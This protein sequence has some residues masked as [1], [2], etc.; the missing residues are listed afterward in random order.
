MIR[1]CGI[2]GYGKLGS[3]LAEMLYAQG[4]LSWIC[5]HSE[6]QY[7]EALKHNVPVHY[8]LDKLEK[9]DSIILSVQDSELKNVSNEVV[10]TGLDTTTWL[11]HCS[12]TLGQE[13]FQMAKDK[14]INT[15][16]IHPFQTIVNKQSLHDI[17]WGIE[18]EKKDEQVI[19]E[20][21]SSLNGNP[22]FLSEETKAHKAAYHATAVMASNF[23]TVLT[24][25]SS[26]AASNA[27][28]DPAIFLP[29]IQKSALQ[30]A[31]AALQNGKSAL[32]MLTGPLLR[33]DIIT[34]VS[35]IESL[36]KN[37]VLVRVY[38][39]LSIATLELLHQSKRI[40]SKQYE[41]MIQQISAHST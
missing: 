29:M 19:G 11:M 10:T 13:V 20:F 36:T 33:G 15:A 21:V 38:I 3:A 18:C 16:C 12:G 9:T 39:E 22:V 25:L 32:D 2:I 4:R 17:P 5:V 7:S 31:H 30:N 28:I 6:S 26:I 34:I 1:T 41:L 8:S 23:M 37:S 14:Q 40:E 27:H 35:Q 24:E